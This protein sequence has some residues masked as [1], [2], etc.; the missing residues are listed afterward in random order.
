MERRLVDT[1]DCGLADGILLR[2]VIERV[3]M[4]RLDGVIEEGGTK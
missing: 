2:K 3:K 1:T 4:K